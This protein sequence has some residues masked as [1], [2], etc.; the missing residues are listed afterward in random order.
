MN[1][2]HGGCDNWC[3]YYGLTPHHAYN[4]QLAWRG[5]SDALFQQI[6][7]LG[8]DYRALECWSGRPHFAYFEVVI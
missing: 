6:D 1:E 3:P 8:L 2:T 5:Y 4:W 7:S